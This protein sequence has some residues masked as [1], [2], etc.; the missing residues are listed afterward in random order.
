M[1][2]DLRHETPQ[3][4]HV[5]AVSVLER[6]DN[7]ES[8]LGAEKYRS[9]S[10]S[11][12][13]IHQ[14][15]AIRLRGR[16]KRRCDVH[17][18]RSRADSA[19]GANDGEDAPGADRS[20]PDDSMD[21]LFQISL[22]DR[23]A[24]QLVDPGAHGFE[25]QRRLQGRRDENNPR[26]RVVPLQC[27]N[28][29]WHLG[30]AADIDHND[31]RLSCRRSRQR[32]EAGSVGVRHLHRGLDDQVLDLA[33]ARSHKGDCD[34]RLQSHFI[35]GVHAHA[36]LNHRM[37]VLRLPAPEPQHTIVG[38]EG[39]QSQNDE[40]D[41]A[42]MNQEGTSIRP[43]PPFEA[44]RMHNRAHEW[45]SKAWQ[46][47]LRLLPRFLR[48]LRVLHFRCV[49]EPAT[50]LELPAK[51]LVDRQEPVLQRRQRGNFVRIERPNEAW[52]D[53]DHQLVA[54]GTDLTA[55]EQVPDDRQLCE[56]R[57]LA[58]QVLRNVIQEPGNC[59]RLAITKFH[60]SFGASCRERRNPE[61]RKSDA[62]RKVQR[63]DLR[64]YL[65]A[66][67]IA[68]DRRREVQADSILLPLHRNG[69][70]NSLDDRNRNF[71]ASQE[72]RVLTVI[73]DQV[74]LG[75]ALEQ[76]FVLKRAD[77]DA[78]IELFIQNEDVQQVAQ[79]ELAFSARHLTTKVAVGLG[80]PQILKPWGRKLS[81]RHPPDGVANAHWTRKQVHAEFSQ[82]RTT[83]LGEPYL[84]QDLLALCA[85]RQLEQ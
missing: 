23:I 65:E 7:R 35:H 28:D 8:R 20:L 85:T 24:D 16:S 46:S 76:A 77:R 30:R 80:P 57:N 39:G 36:S 49:D 62:V 68:G 43:G 47:L 5:E 14:Q 19:L 58:D 38:Y 83:D 84:Q 15:R 78:K 53:Q 51:R 74:R 40:H 63:A 41:E 42:Y 71:T 13:Q 50:S 60:I 18:H 1:W 21:G 31:I 66:N 69:I 54:L 34:H 27:R 33:V 48:P 32:R 56:A 67:G 25:Q 22:R 61:A 11:L 4:N 82:G 9:I 26:L 73:R 75:E 81:G 79:G 37:S 55:F 70:G 29:S 6:V 72:A 45:L 10:T 44:R 64:P 12:V 52:C 17:G 59:E 2:G 3:E